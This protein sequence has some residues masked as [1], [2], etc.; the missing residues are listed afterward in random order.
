MVCGECCPP[1][2]V[3]VAPKVRGIIGVDGDHP[4][5]AP[6][7]VPPGLHEFCS[8]QCEH[9]RLKLLSAGTARVSSL[10]L[11]E[12]LGKLRVCHLVLVLVYKMFAVIVVQSAE[13]RGWPFES[14]EDFLYQG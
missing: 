14:F 12:Q 3:H 4:G 5:I 11:I 7:Q 2:C 9:F 1:V 10:V 8:Q 13:H 6:D